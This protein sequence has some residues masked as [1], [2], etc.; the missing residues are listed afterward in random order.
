MQKAIAF[1]IKTDDKASINAT[2]FKSEKKSPHLIIMGPATGAP[3]HY[4][5]AFATYASKYSD[6]DVLTFDYRGIGKSLKAPIKQSKAKMSDW[7]ALDLKAVIDWSDKKYHKV[8]LLGHSVSGQLFPKAKNHQRINAAYFVGSQSAYMGHWKG[9]FWLQVFVFW[10]ISLPITTALYGYMPGW[11]MGGKVDLPK[12]VAREWRK[13]ALHPQGVLQGNK[14]MVEEFASVRTPLHFVNIMD[15]RLLAPAA[16][17]HALMH[18]YKNAVTSY[19]YIKPKDLG[20]D[21][22]GHF[23]FFKSRFQKKL[24]SMPMFFFTQFVKRLG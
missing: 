7:G 2:L 13:W 17:T 18:C 14:Q 21:E 1:E 11:A 5:R 3:Q 19:Q 6:F 24:W 15:D 8:F 4:Y 22:I 9:L 12:G 23:G 20:L 10:Y 16:A